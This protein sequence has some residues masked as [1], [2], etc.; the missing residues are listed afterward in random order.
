MESPQMKA[1]TAAQDLMRAERLGGTGE[2]PA[3]IASNDKDNN[4]KRDSLLVVE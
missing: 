1:V 2:I 3:A 4:N